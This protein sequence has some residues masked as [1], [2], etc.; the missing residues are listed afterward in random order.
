MMIPLLAEL[1]WTDELPL[2][3]AYPTRVIYLPTCLISAPYCTLDSIWAQAPISRLCSE[4][5][6]S[7]FA[8]IGPFLLAASL[9]VFALPSFPPRFAAL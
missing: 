4:A 2:A 1:C 5:D 3:G 7:H 6:V 9:E 8:Y